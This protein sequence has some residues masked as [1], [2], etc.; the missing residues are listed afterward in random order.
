M[1]EVKVRLALVFSRLQKLGC[2]CSF[3]AFYYIVSH[4]RTASA[5]SKAYRTIMLPDGSRWEILES[6]SYP[7]FALQ[8]PVRLQSILHITC[9]SPGA[10]ASALV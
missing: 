6:L 9:Q 4:L 3:G 7:G 8:P 10:A 1:Q 5:L 2:A